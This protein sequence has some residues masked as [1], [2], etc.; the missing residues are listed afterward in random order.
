MSTRHVEAPDEAEALIEK[1]R[2]PITHTRVS[3]RVFFNG[4]LDEE[5]RGYLVDNINWAWR[6]TNGKNPRETEK[7]YSSW[8][9]GWGPYNELVI[10]RNGMSNEHVEALVESTLAI[11]GHSIE[12]YEDD[13]LVQEPKTHPYT[14]P[15]PEDNWDDYFPGTNY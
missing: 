2:V 9:F 10:S 6:I 13:T 11:M 3:H 15:V 4:E 8:M 5:T 12:I 1:K 7:D 14:P